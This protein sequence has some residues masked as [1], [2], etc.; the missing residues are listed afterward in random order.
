M[1]QPAAEPRWKSVP[2]WF[3][4]GDMDLNVPT[5]VHRFMAERAR[6]RRTIEVAGA[7]HVV[8]ISHPDA[9]AELILQ[10]VSA[11]AP[12]AG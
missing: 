11:G 10:A 6:S 12:A 4:F 2:S 1:S 8:G 7:S 9:L 5:E 3:M